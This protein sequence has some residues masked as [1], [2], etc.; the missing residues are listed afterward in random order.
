MHT[1]SLSDGKSGFSEKHCE[2]AKTPRTTLCAAMK[3]AL[4]IQLIVLQF[5]THVALKTVRHGQTD[6]CHYFEAAQF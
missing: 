2:F 1:Q 4:W 5:L 3:T 6:S